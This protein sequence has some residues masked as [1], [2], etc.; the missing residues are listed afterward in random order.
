MFFQAD[1]KRM[2][3]SHILFKMEEDYNKY[4]EIKQ[5][6]SKEKMTEW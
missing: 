1:L 4:K 3:I 6:V 2:C 5:W